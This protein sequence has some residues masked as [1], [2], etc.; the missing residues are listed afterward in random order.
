MKDNNV[1]TD[2]DLLV[3]NVESLTDTN[4]LLEHIIELRS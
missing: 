3:K 2:I 4:E 1:K